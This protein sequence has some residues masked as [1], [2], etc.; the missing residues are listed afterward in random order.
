LFLSIGLLMVGSAVVAE[1]IGRI[2]VLLDLAA[3]TLG[4]TAG[5]MAL[6]D[7][8]T[9]PFVKI[10]P[11][12]S[13]LAPAIGMALVLL[14]DIMLRVRSARQKRHTRQQIGKHRQRPSEATQT[15]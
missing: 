6:N 12:S 15:R 11:N 4:W 7:F 1:L 10:L 13:L 9:G 5:T 8:Y 14:V 3:L 2:P